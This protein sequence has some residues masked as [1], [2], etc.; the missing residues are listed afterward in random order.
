MQPF[1]VAYVFICDSLVLLAKVDMKRIVRLF[2]LFF[3]VVSLLANQPATAQTSQPETRISDPAE[4]AAFVTALNIQDPAARA[5][6]LEEFLQRYPNSPDKLEAMTAAIDS[7]EQADNLQNAQAMAA[8]VL[9]IAPNN[10]R[11]LAFIASLNSQQNI[12]LLAATAMPTDRNAALACKAASSWT[13][14][15]EE[16][17]P[18]DWEFLLQYRD[19]SPCNRAAADR[20]WQT[21]QRKQGA[22][23]LR[24]PVKVL[25]SSSNEVQAALSQEHQWG[26]VQDL[27]VSLAYPLPYPLP[28]GTETAVAGRLTGYTVSPFSLVMENADLPD[29]QQFGCEVSPKKVPLVGVPVKEYFLE[30]RDG[31]HCA[32]E[33]ADVIWKWMT[34]HAHQV[35]VEVVSAS[36]DAI[37]GAIVEKDWKSPVADL[38][39]ILAKP[40]RSLTHKGT[41][42]RVSGTFSSYSTGPFRFTMENASAP[43]AICAWIK[44]ANLANLSV[45]DWQ[46][47]LEASGDRCLA[48]AGVEVWNSVLQRQQ[49]NG[50]RM[51][52]SGNVV[53]AT[54]E[55]VEAIIGEENLERGK[56]NIAVKM[57]KPLRDLPEV[58]AT[59]EIEGE[60][61]LYDKNPF[62]FI[63]YGG[64]LV[65]KP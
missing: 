29:W 4:R 13:Y 1:C 45:D 28:F 30:H 42:L 16:L 12:R 27:R 9:K 37:E 44:D 53:S 8:A 21:L 55:W 36:Y 10:A 47:V 3:A 48:E 35:T 34:T 46:Y 56:A 54:P 60:L 38:H 39:A 15:W 6:A 51:R 32:S 2:A 26:N 57:T 24:F 63:M 14:E 41:I 20:M 40:L 50:G 58:G 52:F 49:Q 23:K 11:A 17:G 65:S 18:G 62:H 59:V 7:Y 43:E 64:R 5:A 22:F 31:T 61:V 19:A 25:S 33:A